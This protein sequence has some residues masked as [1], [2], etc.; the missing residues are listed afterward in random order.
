MSKTYQER[1]EW[2]ADLY[3]QFPC[4]AFFHI[5]VRPHE[6]DDAVKLAK[7]YWPNAQIK[8]ILTH[9]ELPNDTSIVKVN[10]ELA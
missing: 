9:N 6:L 10:F 4:A 2:H 8:G 3:R 7:T 5:A 1:F